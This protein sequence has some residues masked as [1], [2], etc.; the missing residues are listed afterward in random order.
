MVLC[1][2]LFP[3]LFHISDYKKKLSIKFTLDFGSFNV[4]MTE[5]ITTYFCTFCASN[6]QIRWP[7]I[8]MHNSRYTEYEIYNVSSKNLKFEAVFP[9]FQIG[10]SDQ[11]TL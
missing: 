10:K 4:K 7:I 6:I 8:K 9:V 5:K 2:I 3:A 11:A 1:Y